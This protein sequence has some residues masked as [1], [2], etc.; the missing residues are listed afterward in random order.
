MLGYGDRKISMGELQVNQKFSDP[1]TVTKILQNF[2][3]L[4]IVGIS[5][6]VA[7]L[8]LPTKFK[9]MYHF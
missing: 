9:K 6:R 3:G 7:D 1:E 8:P 4:V 5:L 2:L